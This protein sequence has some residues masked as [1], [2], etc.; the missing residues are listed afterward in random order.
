MRDT[1]LLVEVDDCVPRNRS[2]DWVIAVGNQD[3]FDLF[4][5]EEAETATK[6]PAMTIGLES[7]FADLRDWVVSQVVLVARLAVVGKVT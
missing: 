1:A 3:L 6:D 2:R 4:A 5:G 7:R